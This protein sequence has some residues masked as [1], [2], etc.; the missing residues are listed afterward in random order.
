MKSSRTKKNL[1]IISVGGSLIVPDNININFLKRFRDIILKQV[2][3]GKKFIIIVGGGKTAREYQKALNSLNEPSDYDLDDIGIKATIINARLILSIF[4]KYAYYRIIDNPKNK[5]YF[6]NK[7]L[8]AAGWKPGFSTDYVAVL[9]AKTYNVNKIIN[10]TNVDFVYDKNPK[11]YKNAKRFR[12]L[13][14]DKY[15]SFIKNLWSPGLSTP[16]DPM[17]SKL[18]QKF[19]FVV[20]IMNGSNSKNLENFFD[21]KKFKGT[22]INK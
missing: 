2:G 13:S 18:A 9:L 3:K 20:Y 19:N 10:L 1:Y 15:L 17:A 8:V 11:E 7:I 16:F 4:K 6:K 12:L 14:W 21:G 5:I 22:I